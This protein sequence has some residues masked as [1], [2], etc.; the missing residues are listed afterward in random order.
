MN[1]YFSLALFRLKIVSRLTGF[2]EEEGRTH[3]FH[4]NVESCLSSLQ[5]S[6]IL[7][8]NQWVSL[9]FSESSRNFSQYCTMNFYSGAILTRFSL[10]LRYSH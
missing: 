3:A 1:K 9:R 2:Q 7:N 6:I 4:T 10:N 5:D 8:L